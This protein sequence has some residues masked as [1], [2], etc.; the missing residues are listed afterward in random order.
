MKTNISELVNYI[1]WKCTGITKKCDNYM[2]I[3]SET[4]L[5]YKVG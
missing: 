3:S 2:A 4:G 1:D 5:S